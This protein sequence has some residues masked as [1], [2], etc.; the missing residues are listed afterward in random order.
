M[1][2]LLDRGGGGTSDV[3]RFLSRQ[4]YLTLIFYLNKKPDILS[5]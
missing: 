3:G 5:E 1:V 4:V 2:I